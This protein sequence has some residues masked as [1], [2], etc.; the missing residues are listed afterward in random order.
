MTNPPIK[1]L[2]ELLDYDPE[3]NSWRWRKRAGNTP[4]IKGFN[5]RW[6][7]KFAGSRVPVKKPRGGWKLV[8]EI[9]GRAYAADHPVSVFRSEK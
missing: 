8:I 3:E 6:A 7:G 1:R 9:D 5:T 4:G 2:R